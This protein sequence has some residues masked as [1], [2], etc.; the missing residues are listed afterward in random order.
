MG[1]EAGLRNGSHVTLVVMPEEVVLSTHEQTAG[2]DDPFYAGAIEQESW[3]FPQ[4]TAQGA[5]VI[6]YLIRRQELP[7]DLSWRQPSELKAMS[8]ELIEAIAPF[9]RCKAVGVVRSASEH[10]LTVLMDPNQCVSEREAIWLKSCT[11][12]RGSLD[13]VRG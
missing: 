7:P 13:A 12:L 11:V 4:G 8:R 5:P 2:I 1:A 3:T 6:Y 10:L 9:E